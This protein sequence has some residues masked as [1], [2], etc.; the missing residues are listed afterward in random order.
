[1]TTRIEIFKHSNIL[2]RSQ[3]QMRGRTH[4]M[5]V[6]YQKVSPQLITGG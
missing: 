4:H 2:D 1:M 3:T 5:P 6:A